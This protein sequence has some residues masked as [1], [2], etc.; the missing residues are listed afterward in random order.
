MDKVI[1]VFYSGRV[2]GVGL[3]YTA[4]DV[5]REMGIGG[6]VKNLD[7]GRVEVLAQAD[8]QVLKDFLERISRHFSRYIQH[9]DAEWLN[10]AGELKDFDVKF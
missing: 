1:H 2:Q 6:W 9:A 4:L 8:E 7:D 10:P 3:R 5:A